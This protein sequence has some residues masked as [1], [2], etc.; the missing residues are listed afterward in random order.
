MSGNVWEFV[1][2]CWHENYKDAPADGSAWLQIGKENCS[3]P[4][5]GGGW[6][7][8]PRSLRAAVRNR[9]RAADDVYSLGGFRLTRTF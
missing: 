5:R 4:V 9:Y 3:P 2:D 7:N 8:F 1:A 6:F